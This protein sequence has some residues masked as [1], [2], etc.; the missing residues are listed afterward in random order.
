MLKKIGSLDRPKNRPRDLLV[1]A[2]SRTTLYF[3]MRLF[4]IVPDSVCSFAHSSVFRSFVV[5]FS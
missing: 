2:R 5:F 1:F 4:G 3:G